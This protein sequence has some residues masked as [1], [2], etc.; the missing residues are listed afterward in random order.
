MLL[1]EMN[2]RNARDERRTDNQARTI[3]EYRLYVALIAFFMLTLDT[4][5]IIIIIII[6]ACSVALF[7][8]LIKIYPQRS[9]V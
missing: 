4:V 3:E 9:D 7:L 1:E 2:V 5:I 8:M 6:I